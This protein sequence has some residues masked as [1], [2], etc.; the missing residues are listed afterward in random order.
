MSTYQIDFILNYRNKE[1]SYDVINNIF[2]KYNIDFHVDNNIELFIQGLTHESFSENIENYDK[3]KEEY[4]K[5]NP[6]MVFIKNNSYERLEFLGDAIIK[7]II[8]I[9]LFNRYPYEQEGFLS[10]LRTKIEST[11]SLSHFFQ[12]LEL[13]DYIL[14]SQSFE[15]EGNRDNIHIMEDC[16]E[17]FIGALY[18]YGTKNNDTYD[19]IMSII[20]K[21]MNI[22][23]ETELNLTEL[24]Q[25]KDYKGEL[26]IYCHKAKYP[27]PVYIKNNIQSSVVSHNGKYATNKEMYLYS[28]SVQVNGKVYGPTSDIVLKE[29]EQ[30]AAQL[31][32]EYLNNQN[33]NDDDIFY[34]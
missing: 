12:C 30:K 18:M 17:A 1:V 15:Q 20:Q 9:Y 10:T 8:S 3:L 26:N 31:A 28:V 5:K 32:L 27:V 6:K 14:M 19:K 22:L 25:I 4:Y 24:I 11:K 16:F 23:I 34:V 7:P 21:L 33:N 29:A 2:K 13:K